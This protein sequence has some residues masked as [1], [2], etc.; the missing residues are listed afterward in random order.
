[1]DL[2]NRLAPQDVP[3][4]FLR[5]FTW[6]KWASKSTPI[7]KN[8]KTH[9]QKKHVCLGCFLNGLPHQMPPECYPKTAS[10]RNVFAGQA[11][12]EKLR[13]DCAGASGSR[14]GPSRKPIK[15]HKNKL[16]TNTPRRSASEP[17][18]WW[19][20]VCAVDL[21]EVKNKKTRCCVVGTALVVSNDMCGW[22]VIARIAV[23]QSADILRQLPSVQSLSKRN[24]TLPPG[25]IQVVR[26][27]P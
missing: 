16:R 15:M 8:T 3:A 26:T 1:M 25:E 13:F 7:I 5:R 12:N 27:S 4:A 22:C 9:V 18:F 11:E 17:H 21:K 2:Q 14:V 6:Q 20:L 23:Q 19:I 10:K 24:E